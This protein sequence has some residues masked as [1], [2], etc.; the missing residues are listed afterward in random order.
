MHALQLQYS[1]SA[2]RRVKKKRLVH[3]IENKLRSMEKTLGEVLTVDGCP[4]SFIFQLPGGL[5][6]RLVKKGS[7]KLASSIPITA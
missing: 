7:A 2:Q 4:V 5:V 3:S 1:C 6:P